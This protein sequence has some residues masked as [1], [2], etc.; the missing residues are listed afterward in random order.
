[1]DFCFLEI[2]AFSHYRTAQTASLF[3]RIPTPGVK[4]TGF[5]TETKIGRSGWHTVFG[6]EKS[7]LDYKVLRK[8]YGTTRQ[9]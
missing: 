8:C 6:Q 3:G 5:T 2:Y 9:R 1:A 7:R 4:K